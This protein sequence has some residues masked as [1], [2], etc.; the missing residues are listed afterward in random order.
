MS[1]LLGRSIN[2]SAI[3]SLLGQVPSSETCEIA[4]YNSPSQL[5]I[6]G[7]RGGLDIVETAA[8]SQ[9]L[10]ARATPLVVSGAFHS[11]LMQPAQDS[12]ASTLRVLELAEAKMKKMQLLSTVTSE[13]VSDVNQLRELL[14]RQIT[15]PVRW[16]QSIVRLAQLGY[17]EFVEVGG[18][19]VLC[20]L[21]TQIDPSL[22]TVSLSSSDD[23]DAFVSKLT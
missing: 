7:T 20:K 23:V 22:R 9:G 14:L 19:G 1:A 21:V 2:A 15:A 5:V 12:L 6:S 11:A 13:Q 4:N 17:R 18:N 16:H 3:E 8:K 10:I